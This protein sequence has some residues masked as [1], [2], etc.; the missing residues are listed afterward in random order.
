VLVRWDP[1]S[2]LDDFGFAALP[3][4]CVAHSAA[5]LPVPQLPR[6]GRERAETFSLLCMQWCEGWSGRA[7]ASHKRPAG[8]C[9]RCAAACNVASPRR[10]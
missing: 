1:A 3:C 10:R 2:L 9:H 5:Q 6:V 7:G 4:S 8:A